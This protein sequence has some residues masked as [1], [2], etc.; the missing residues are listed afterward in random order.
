MEADT[1]V[2][3]HPISLNIKKKFQKPT[4]E[5]W[6]LFCLFFI[7]GMPRAQPG[8]RSSSKCSSQSPWA[9]QAVVT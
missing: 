7:A 4:F 6:L 9:L 5:E 2:C 3:F 8:C 1:V